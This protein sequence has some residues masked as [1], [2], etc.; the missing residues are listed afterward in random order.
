MLAESD[1]TI[2]SI[3]AAA[4][5]LYVTL[6]KDGRS[7]LRRIPYSGG[8]VEEVALPFS[9]W[10]DYVH[11]DPMRPGGLVAIES[12]TRDP[13]YFSFEPKKHGFSE[14]PLLPKGDA[15]FSQ[16]VAEETTVSTGG[17]DVPL[18]I[19]HRRDL[20]LD[21]SHPAIVFGYGAYGTV[22][23]PTYRPALLP[24]LERG[25]VWAIA[26]VRGGGEKGE[27]WRKGAW[28]ETKPN[29][30]RD[31]N[32]CAEWLVQKR[33][34]SRSKLGAYSASAGGILVGRAITERPELYVAASIYAGEV[35]ASRY[36]HGSNGANQSFELGPDDT[37]DGLETLLAM[38]AYQSVRD[39]VPYPAVMLST[40]LN[41][42]RVSPWMS[43]KLAARL[44]GATSS[45]RPILLR[46]E[47]DEGHGVGSRREQR[48]AFWADMFTFFLEQMG[49]P[50]FKPASSR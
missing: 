8:R 14:L 20:P 19:L 15:D 13:A 42:S 33:Y 35:N 16:I 11:V 21:G 4:D 7:A 44:K 46:V 50:D 30:W 24:W 32:A 47:G 39:G 37:H 9:G 17:V 6:Q 27:A 22:M 29:A 25:G 1:A 2:E 28:R 49:D 34:T 18:T 48:L 5:A 10:V 26:H 31:F 3:A 40:G 43:A 45:E 41:D 36:M 12:W 23:S 38:D